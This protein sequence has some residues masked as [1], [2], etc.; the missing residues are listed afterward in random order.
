[1]ARIFADLTPL[2][3]SA[4][5]RRLW[6]GLGISNV[7][8]QMTSVAVG[9][10][11]YD[12]TKSSFMVGLVGLFQLIP[13]IGFGLYGGTLSDAFDRRL[14]GLISALGLWGCSIL[15]MLQSALSINSVGVLFLVVAVQSAFFAVGNPARQA[16]IPRLVPKEMLPA[17]NAL[18]M[19]T[20][21]IGFTLGPL[22]GGLVIAAFGTVSAAYVIDVVAFAIVVWAMWRLPSLPPILI[23][24]DVRPRAGWGAVKEGFVFLKG[25]RNLQM[26]FYE[27]IIAMVFGMPRALFPAIAAQ[28]YGGSMREVAMV[29]GFLAAAPA[30]GALLSSIFSGPLGAV[31]AQGRWVIISIVVWGSTI[32][33]FG[34]VRWLPLALLL[35][36]IAGAADNVSAIFRTTIMQ[37]ATPDE[38]RGRLQGIFTVVVAGG[39]RLGDVEAGAV[40]AVAGEAFSVISGGVMCVVLALGLGRAIP[41]FWKYDARH[42][43]P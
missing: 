14:V 20:W 2:R 5:Y 33:A 3:V 35:L 28:W 9:L 1:M 25:K 32:A 34:M 24:G 7:G 10:Q 30:V 6:A 19:I 16:I 11:V 39:P 23:A 15:F 26:S 31:R 42:P 41:S 27:D 29:L 12:L 4:P 21:N 37:S 13:L 43:I 18:S 40:A 38:Y 22:I 17:A 36:M 8:Q